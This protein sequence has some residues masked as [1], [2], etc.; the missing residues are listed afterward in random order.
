VIG[1][2]VVTGVRNTVTRNSPRI[3]GHR[4]TVT[5]IVA[6]ELMTAAGY[7]MTRSMSMEG[8]REPVSAQRV[9]APAMTNATVGKSVEPTASMESAASTV[10]SGKSMEPTTSAVKPTT[11]STMKPTT[12]STVKAATASATMPTATAPTA[13][14]SDCRSVRDDAKRANRNARCQNTYCFLFHGG[15]AQSTSKASGSQRSRA[16]LPNLT[17]VDAASFGLGKSKFH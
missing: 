16:D 14:P 5:E 4:V 12:A 15:F 13:M 2:R 1:K 11:A 9:A 17:I 10:K 6:S 8:V 3:T 7:G